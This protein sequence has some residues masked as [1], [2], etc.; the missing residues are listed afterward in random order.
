MQERL[1]F[2]F[3]QPRICYF[4]ALHRILDLASGAN[5]R[6]NHIGASNDA[7]QFIVVHDGQSLDIV[8]FD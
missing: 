6:S 4:I 8:F 5:N 1:S 7:H 2:Q 3:K